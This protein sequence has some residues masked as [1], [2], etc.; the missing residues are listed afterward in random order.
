MH[1]TPDRGMATA[2]YAVGTLGVVL[3]ASLLMKLGDPD[4]WF[5]RHLADIFTTAL[6]PSTV[7]KFIQHAHLPFL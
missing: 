5:F 6:D 3:I 1:P 4:G 2:E 7:L